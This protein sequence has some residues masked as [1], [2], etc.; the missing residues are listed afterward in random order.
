[1]AGLQLFDV[2]RCGV[3]RIGWKRK[4]FVLNWPKEAVSVIMRTIMFVFL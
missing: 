1:M 3:Y 4:S 2:T